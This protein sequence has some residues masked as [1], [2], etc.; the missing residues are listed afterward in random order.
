MMR[1]VDCEG[2]FPCAGSAVWCV[3]ECVPPWGALGEMETP[4]QCGVLRAHCLPLP[5]ETVGS[6]SVCR[7]KVVE[8]LREAEKKVVKLLV[9]VKDK[10]RPGKH[11][12]AFPRSLWEG[13]SV[14][15]GPWVASHLAWAGAH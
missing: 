9:N 15:W 7:I 6:Y 2:L 3:G 13:G 14:Q 10:V 5:F 11:S 8:E 1:F 12:C 4:W